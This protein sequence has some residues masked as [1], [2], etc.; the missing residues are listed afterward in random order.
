VT[1]DPLDDY[2]CLRPL[3]RGLDKYKVRDDRTRRAIDRR[4]PAVGSLL[5]SASSSRSSPSLTMFW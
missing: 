2:V 3:H 5:G 4:Y 1:R